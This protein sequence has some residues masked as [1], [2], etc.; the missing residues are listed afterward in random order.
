MDVFWGITGSGVD[1]TLG[2]YFT[3]GETCN[4]APVLE[5]DRGCRL[6]REQLLGGTPSFQWVVSQHGTPLYAAEADTLAPPAEGWQ[7]REGAAPPPTVHSHALEEE[8]AQAVVIGLKGYGNFRF[9]QNDYGAAAELYTRALAIVSKLSEDDP[10]AADIYSNRAEARLRLRSWEAALN[11][12][13]EAIRRKPDHS[14]AL[15]RGATAAMHLKRLCEAKRLV[16]CCLKFNPYNPDAQQLAM[17]LAHAAEKALA[18]KSLS[19]AG[20]TSDFG[21]QTS[22]FGRQVSG[23]GRQTSAMSAVTALAALSDDEDL[24]QPRNRRQ[25]SEDP[26]TEKL[27]WRCYQPDEPLQF[28][29]LD[30]KLIVRW[31]LPERIAHSE[32]RVTP[33]RNGKKLRVAACGVVT[34]K[35][36]LFDVIVPGDLTWSVSDRHELEVIMTKANADLMWKQVWA[37]GGAKHTDRDDHMSGL[38]M[39]AE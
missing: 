18:K 28:E 16:D 29:Q 14:K 11:D 12:A 35:G 19:F 26:L 6:S 22:G 30:D 2:I 7:L 31:M 39:L 8:V 27:L 9:M 38:S 5:N 15:L 23:F 37:V 3:N 25:L 21:R 36:D 13:M 24:D 10:A 1:E 4:E 32:V 33:S 34:F 17:D 20:D